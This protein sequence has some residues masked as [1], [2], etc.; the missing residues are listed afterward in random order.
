MGVALFDEPPL[1]L[2]IADLSAFRIVNAA[3][4]PGAP[5]AAPH[6]V[7]P[8]GEVGEGVPC[9]RPERL[10]PVAGPAL[11]GTHAGDLRPGLGDRFMVRVPTELMGAKLRPVSSTTPGNRMR[12]TSGTAGCSRPFAPAA[13]QPDVVLRELV[14]VGR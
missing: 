14:C 13:A 6:A 7:V 2:L 12:P 4:E 5:A 8:P 11:G 1:V 10:N 9:L 3:V